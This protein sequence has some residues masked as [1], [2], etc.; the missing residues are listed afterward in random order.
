VWFEPLRRAIHDL[1]IT[2]V[3]TTAQGNAAS[4]DTTQGKRNT[5]EMLLVILT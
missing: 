4:A 3:T 5:P 2:Q 1:P